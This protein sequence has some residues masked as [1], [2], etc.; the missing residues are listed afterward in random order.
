MTVYVD[1]ITFSSENRISKRFREQIFAIVRK[2]G[3]QIS[4]SKVKKYTKSY[5]KLVTGVIID[6][7]GKPAIKNSMHEKIIHEFART[8]G[9]RKISAAFKGAF[10]SGE[11][12]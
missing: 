8:S 2:Y 12:G 10:D 7:T 5:P 4:R 6:S 11:T 9:R 1:D 3:Y